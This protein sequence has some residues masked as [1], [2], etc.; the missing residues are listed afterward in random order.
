M[1]LPKPRS[2][3][4]RQRLRLT[5]QQTAACS[6]FLRHLVQ[7][8]SLSG[9]ESAVARITAAEMHR[10]G[11]ESVHTDRI[12]N[13]IGRYGQPGGPILLLNAHMDTVDTGDPSA[14]THDPFGAEIIEQ[15][16]YGRGSVDMKGPLAAMLYGVSIL[17]EQGISLPGEV[18]VAAVVQ[19]EPTEGMAMRVLVE[20]EGLHPDWVILGEP[21]NLQIAR[22]QR[23]RM[24]IRVSTFGRSCHASTP[25]KGENALYGAARLIFGIELLNA[26]L[27]QDAILGKGSLAVTQLTTVAGSR[28]AIPDRCDFVIDRR[29][30]LGETAQR[31]L[32]EIEALLQREGVRGRVDTGYYRS[33]SYTGYQTEGPEIYPAWLLA[34]DNPLLLQSSASIEKTLGYRPQIRTWGFSTDGVYTMGEAGI[35]TLGFGPGDDHLAH[36]ADE[37]IALPDV[38]R[39][40]QAYANLSIDLINYLASHRAATS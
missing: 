23:G 35:P 25:E 36:T 11:F 33:T 9:Q 32:A 10:L 26:R 40:A 2:S 21:T 37:H 3:H 29:L 7:T 39:A 5:P 8:P 34:E 12:G 28:N 13:V 27:M 4:D 31:A 15:Q 19:E 14:W 6:D 30:T 38:F 18:V 24:E 22:G 17:I 1:A 20:E 16:L